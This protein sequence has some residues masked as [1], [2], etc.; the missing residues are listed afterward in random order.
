MLGKTIYIW[1]DG[2]IGNAP[3]ITA[4]LQQ[5]GFEGAILHS[6]ATTNWRTPTR[7]ALASAIKAAGL[8]VY[9][10]CAVYGNNA[11]LEGQQAAGIVEQYQLAG[12]VFDAES[13]WDSQA[14]AAANA[15]EMLYAYKNMTA[16]PSGWCWWARYKSPIT[17]GAWHP[18][19]VL[20]EA[21]KHADFG[22]PMAYWYGSTA[23]EAM[24]LLEQSWNQWREITP[25]PLVPIGRAYNG[26]G[27]T[28][29][30]TGI[31][32]FAQHART[33]GAVGTSWWVMEHA[34]RLA[35]IWDALA[36]TRPFA[37]EPPPP[38]TDDL[39]TRLV[40]IESQLADQEAILAGHAAKFQKI[41]DAAA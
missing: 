14:A 33:L 38:S 32:A 16:Q 2:A 24:T 5:A 25:K 23:G 17:N 27:G 18:V 30:P 41:S 28:A 37:A 20:I 35:G 31:A 6:T 29:T 22:L 9:A 12:C 15:R 13:Q 36:Q 10:G 11:V 39:T 8:K 7:I 3:A 26:D 40:Q 34:I 4:R 21:M 19:A 1:N